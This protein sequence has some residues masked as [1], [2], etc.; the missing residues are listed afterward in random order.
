REVGHHQALVLGVAAEVA[1]AAWGGRHVSVPST[2]LWQRLSGNV[3]WQL[4]A[5]QR[6]AALVELLL[7]L[8]E[9]LLSEVGDVEQVVLGLGEQLT[10]RVDLGSLEAVARALGEVEILDREIEVGRAGGGV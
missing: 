7:D 8:V 9:A 10:D 3:S 6:E 1:G 4:S 2:F 5:T